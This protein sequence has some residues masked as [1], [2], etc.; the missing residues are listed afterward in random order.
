MSGNMFARMG[1]PLLNK[2]LN[3]SSQRQRIIAGNIA[4][5]TTP[6]Y[7][8]Q[9]LNFEE[10]LAQAMGKKGIPGLASDPRHI[11]LGNMNKGRQPIIMRDTNSGVDIEKEMSASAENQLLYST[12]AKL[13]SGKFKS[14]RT[15]IRGRG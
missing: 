1:I 11:P 15:V 13:V 5:A 3:V 10:N 2:V 4:N 14:L 12:V 9:V 6:G 8:K 7:N